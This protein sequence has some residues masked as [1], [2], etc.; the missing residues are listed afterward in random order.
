MSRSQHGTFLTFIKFHRI[1]GTAQKLKGRTFCTS[2]L[3]SIHP[4][5]S[6]Y[7]DKKRNQIC[8]FSSSTRIFKQG[9]N[10][11][12]RPTIPES[13]TSKK[14]LKGS[15]PGGQKINKT[16]SAVQVHHEPTGLV[17]KVQA[18]RSRSINETIARR[19]LAE[20]VEVLQKGDQSR[21]KVKEEKMRKKKNSAIKK[22]RRKYKALALEAGKEGRLTGR[23]AKTLASSGLLEAAEGFGV[24]SESMDDEQD[25]VNEAAENDAK[26]EQTEDVPANDNGIRS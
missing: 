19:L 7:T 20:K 11:P 25:P 9:A 21:V 18:T 13:E 10:L 4:K 16:N 24:Q 8:L 17:V 26:H 2:A 12:P 3:Y 15:G 1:P 6:L 22:S 14:Y 5:T 23:A